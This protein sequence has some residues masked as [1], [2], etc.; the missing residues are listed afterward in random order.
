[1]LSVRLIRLTSRGETV[2]VCG[3][4]TQMR[5]LP[6]TSCSALRGNSIRGLIAELQ[7]HADRRAQAK[8]WRRFGQ[9]QAGAAGTGRALGLGF[10]FAN[11]GRGGDARVQLR[12]DLKH[13]VCGQLV[14]QGVGQVDHRFLDVRLRQGHHLLAGGDDLPGFG[15][16]RR[17]DGLVIGAQL[18]VVELVLGLTDRSLGLIEGGLGGFQ[19]GLGDVQLRLGA[20]PAIEQF[21]LAPGVGLGIDE[22]RLD[23]RQIALAERNWFCW[24]VGSSVASKA[25]LSTSAPT[26]TLRLAM[27]PGTRKPT[28]LS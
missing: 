9:G 2:C 25:P 3:S 10:D 16:P 5:V 4:M 19:V 27:R 14:D 22:L 23:A 11:D 21:L 18:N 15:I 20:H 17:D 13:H 26:S 8:A 1:M 24:S 7:G 12:G 6:S 28:L